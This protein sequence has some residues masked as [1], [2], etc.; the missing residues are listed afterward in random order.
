[1]QLRIYGP[2]TRKLLARLECVNH[3]VALVDSPDNDMASDLRKI[4][5]RG[6]SEWRGP[7]Q[8]RQYRLTQS[9]HPEFL[10]RLAEYLARQYNF[11]Y[12][13]IEEL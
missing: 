9:T 7:P 11:R 3:H 4:I 13:L 2:Y 1:M 8:H 6:L 5:L 12:A 10:P